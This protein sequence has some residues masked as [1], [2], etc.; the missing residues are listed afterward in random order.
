MLSFMVDG[1][2][3]HLVEDYFLSS[4]HSARKTLMTRAGPRKTVYDIVTSKLGPIL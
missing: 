1:S 4:S 3:E 2:R